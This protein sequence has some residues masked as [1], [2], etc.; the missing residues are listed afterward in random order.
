LRSLDW[1]V[2]D[3]RPSV[4]AAFNSAVQVALQR[5]VYN[6]GGCT[7]YY[8]D[9]NGRNSTMWPWSTVRMMRRIRSFEPADYVISDVQAPARSR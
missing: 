7:S 1:P 2:A 3:V 5:T 9:A 8:L 4:Q 6:A